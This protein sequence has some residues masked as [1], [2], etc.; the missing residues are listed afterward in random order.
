MTMSPLIFL[1]VTNSHCKT[2]VTICTTRVNWSR[3]IST[4][5]VLRVHTLCGTCSLAA[6]PMWDHGTFVW[7]RGISWSNNE[8][9]TT[10]VKMEDDFRCLSCT[11]DTSDGCDPEY[12][13]SIIKVIKEACEEFCPTF[14]TCVYDHMST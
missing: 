3:Y 9:V 11:I 1:Q 8:G 13:L 14:S 4:I 6:A 12:F 10:V 2:G 5:C 7:M